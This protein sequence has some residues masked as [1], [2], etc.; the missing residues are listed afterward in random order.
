MGIDGFIGESQPM[1]LLIKRIDD[2]ADSGMNVLILGETGTGKELVAQSLHQ[3]G[4]RKNKKFAVV[5]CAGLPDTLVES[6]LYGHAKGAFTGALRDRVGRFEYANGGTLL[7][8][9]IGDMEIGSQGSLLRVLDKREIVRIG[10][11]EARPI[12]CRI[13][14]STNRNLAQLVSEGKF[15]EDLYYRLAVV[16]L[17][18]PP[19]RER[20]E[21]IPLLANHYFSR[22]CNGNLEDISPGAM[23]MLQAYNW[24]GNVRELRNLMEM[25]CGTHRNGS[26]VL[27]PEDA[28]LA[29]LRSKIRYV[30]IRSPK[31]KPWH[32][33]R[34]LPVSL[35]EL[36]NVDG[37]VR[38]EVL[39]YLASK[40]IIYAV[41]FGGKSK[42]YLLFLTE[43]KLDDVFERR[44]EKFEELLGR[45]RTCQFN[46]VKSEP[47]AWFTVESL[48][49]NHNTYG[50]KGIL[51]HRLEAA[52][53]Y[54][55]TFRGRITAYAVPKRNAG[56]LVPQRRDRE[57]K[58]HGFE[59][60]IDS[61]YARFQ[62]GP[63]CT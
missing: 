8:D 25:A 42:Y 60:Y 11:N 49:G 1:K 24:P 7:L 17:T 15:R 18:V 2:L 4:S 61:E 19:L 46:H 34:L 3:M 27:T 22:F 52:C 54:K 51:K 57:E 37:V 55:T 43:S 32:N 23:S 62:A 63:K 14:A 16:T 31:P 10:E 40:N 21:D 20:V 39:S 56:M 29:D 36:R 28:A 35:A 6:E 44:A 50:N 38:P 5:N 59:A 26:K 13:L 47:H 58:L 30:D 9:E 33:C 45:I 53:S 48:L 41:E 12:D